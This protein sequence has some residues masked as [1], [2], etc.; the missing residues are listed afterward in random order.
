MFRWIMMIWQF[1][2]PAWRKVVKPDCNHAYGRTLTKGYVARK[3]FVKSM[4]IGSALM[5][6]V[7]PALPVVIGLGLFTTFVSFMYLDE[8]KSN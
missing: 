4:W 5:M 8:V 6:L 7:M 2:L 3:S 1:L